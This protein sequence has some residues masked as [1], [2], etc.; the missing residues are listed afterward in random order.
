MT[1]ID[2]VYNVEQVLAVGDGNAYDVTDDAL[3]VVEYASVHPVND[4][5]IG[6]VELI[7]EVAEEASRN[8]TEHILGKSLRSC[9][10]GEVGYDLGLAAQRVG[11]AYG[12]CVSHGADVKIS[13]VAHAYK[14]DAA[15]GAGVGETGAGLNIIERAAALRGH[16]CDVVC[17]HMSGKNELHTRISPLGCDL[18]IVFD[19][20]HGHEG[21]LH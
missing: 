1:L 9:V 12:T 21:R 14:L 11:V 5:G 13:G 6:D 20:V 10:L 7:K 8:G 15:H 17:V 2:V 19:E 3:N 16:H 18:L 4:L